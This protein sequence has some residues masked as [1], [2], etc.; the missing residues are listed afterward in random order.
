MINQEEYEEITEFYYKRTRKHIELVCKYIDII[1]KSDPKKYYLLPNRRGL[2]DLSKYKYPELEPYKLLTWRYHCKDIGREFKINKNTERQIHIATYHHI[3]N[4]PHHPEF[5]DENTTTD[6][7]N[8][9]D[10]DKPPENMVDG[11]KMTE[12]DI[13]E[14]IADWLAM[15]EEKKT[16]PVKWAQMN[17]NRRWK[18]TEDQI[19]QIYELIKLYE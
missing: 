13:G 8:S 19:K 10:R 4:N 16:D 17:I 9:R 5:H 6:N 2:H 18:F 12:T 1:Y 14:M 3:K 15:S 11:T 7:L